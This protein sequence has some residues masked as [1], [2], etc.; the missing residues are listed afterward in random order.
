MGEL[1]NTFDNLTTHAAESH[2]V[3]SDNR[4]QYREHFSSYLLHSLK[5]YMLS[6]GVSSDSMSCNF[7]YLGIVSPTNF[8]L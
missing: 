4:N 1:R 8:V 3:N 5:A 2:A 6:F 7:A